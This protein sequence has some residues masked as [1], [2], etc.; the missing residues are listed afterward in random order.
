MLPDFAVA[1]ERHDSRIALEQLEFLIEACVNHAIHRQ[2]LIVHEMQLR[3]RILLV[4]RVIAPQV[5]QPYP[6]A[7][8]VLGD[9]ARSVRAWR[10]GQYSLGELVGSF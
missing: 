7:I 8:Q 4:Q 10:L 1:F 9:L 6:G 5:I 3:L 2:Q